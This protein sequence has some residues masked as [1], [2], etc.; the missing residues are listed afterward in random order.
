M[1]VVLQN[2]CSVDSVN[3]REEK[4]QGRRHSGSSSAPSPTDSRNA[5]YSHTTAC[6]T[7][8]RPASNIRPFAS[9]LFPCFLFSLVVRDN[10]ALPHST[11]VTVKERETRLF[12]WKMHAE[13][14]M[15]QP[16]PSLSLRRRDRSPLFPRFPIVGHISRF[17]HTHRETDR[18]TDRIAGAAQLNKTESLV[19]DVPVCYRI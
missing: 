5:C 12:S 11:Q 19:I 14:E 6:S 17:A 7:D 9:F 2:I 18:W 13:Q 3:R 15:H 8:V 10:R 1:H 4:F 16:N